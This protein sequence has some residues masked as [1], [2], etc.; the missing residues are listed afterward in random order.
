[1]LTIKGNLIVLSLKNVRYDFM[2]VSEIVA[3]L[4]MDQ[5]CHCACAMRSDYPILL[6]DRHLIIEYVT[7]H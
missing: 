4:D 2:D 6:F 5:V 7:C 1:M 3:E